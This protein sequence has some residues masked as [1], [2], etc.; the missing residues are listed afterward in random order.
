MTGEMTSA[1]CFMSQVGAGSSAHCFAGTALSRRHIS[2]S[3]TSL[4]VD[5]RSASVH[6]WITGGGAPAVAQCTSAL[7]SGCPLLQ[8][9]AEA[10]DR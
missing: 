6:A 7:S 5:N 3:V 10:L 2:S 9:N 1:S 4:K 8:G